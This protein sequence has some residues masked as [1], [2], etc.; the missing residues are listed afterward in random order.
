MTFPTDFYATPDPFPAQMTDVP[1]GS[2]IIKDIGANLTAVQQ[3]VGKPGSSH[4]VQR[5][6][7][8]AARDAIIPAPVAGMVCSVAGRPQVNL[9]GTIGGWQVITEPTTAWSPALA[10][11]SANPV[12]GTG[13]ATG[14]WRSNCG[15]V[16][17]WGQVTA[18]AGSNGGSGTWRV[19]LPSPA[20]PDLPRSGSGGLGLPVGSGIYRFATGRW[21]EFTLQLLDGSTCIFVLDGDPHGGAIHSGFP[22]WSDGASLRFQIRY[23]QG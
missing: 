9:D 5:F 22:G 19:S 14:A 16:S 3:A 8:D 18:G 15:E 2:D 21:R 12:L 17:G 6:A 4:V 20:H 7:D 10:A 11:V 13:T 1:K 23:F